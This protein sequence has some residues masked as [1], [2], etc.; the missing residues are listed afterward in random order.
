MFIGLS[1]LWSG[2]AAWGMATLVVRHFQLRACRERQAKSLALA[3]AE[4]DR[5][6]Q[7]DKAA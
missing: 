7:L 4:L 1:V 6:R 5:Y 3:L 2:F